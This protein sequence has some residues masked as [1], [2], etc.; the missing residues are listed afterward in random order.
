MGVE[1][2]SAVEGL[3]E[4]VPLAHLL[5]QVA[6]AYLFHYLREQAVPLCKKAVEI[7]ELM[8]DIELQADALSTLGVLEVWTG[9]N[10]DNPFAT[11]PRAVMLAEASGSLYLAFRANSN[12]G[13]AYY[14]FQGR[15]REAL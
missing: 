8:G 9:E 7:G 11:L 1:A 13:V 2:L 15:H 6:R 12:L 14:R 10:L 3:E 4:G 5:H